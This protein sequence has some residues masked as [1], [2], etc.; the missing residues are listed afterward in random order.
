MVEF[1][2]LGDYAVNISEKAADLHERKIPLSAT[3]SSELLILQD[4][5]ANILDETRLS[6]EKR[7]VDA[8]YRIEP[9]EE[10]VDDLVDAMKQNHLKRLAEGV[11]NIYAGTDFMDLL[12]DIERISDICSNVGLATVTRVNPD[13]ANKTHDYAYFLHSGRDEFFNQEYKVA[14]DEF[15][16]RL[17]EL[18]GEGKIQN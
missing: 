2:R 7:D 13:L 9:L 8:A 4:V 16:G 14:H 3:A 6:F 12:A 11:C 15:Y 17:D 1:E 10:V 5:I 18:I